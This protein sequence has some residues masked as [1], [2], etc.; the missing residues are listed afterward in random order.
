M[1]ERICKIYDILIQ[2][3]KKNQIRNYIN[4]FYT[5]YLLWFAFLGL[6]GSW[7][8]YLIQ[9]GQNTPY[10][11]C[12][13]TCF[14]A[15]SNTGF[16]TI[17]IQ[18]VEWA[19]Q[20]LILILVCL[21]GTIFNCTFPLFVRLIVNQIKIKKNVTSFEFYNGEI[22]EKLKHLRTEQFALLILI[23]VSFAYITVIPIIGSL[24]LIIYSGSSHA[25]HEVYRESA[26]NFGWGSIFFGVSGFH[27]ASFSVLNLGIYPFA[28]NW[29]YLT[30]IG[31]LVL[32]GEALAPFL[33]SCIVKILHLLTLKQFSPL[34]LL[35]SRGR[36]YHPFIFS[37]WHTF[38]SLLSVLFFTL[39]QFVIV[40]SFDFNYGEGELA[41]FSP[42]YRVWNSFFIAINTRSGGY[43]T[44]NYSLCSS[45]SLF[46]ITIMFYVP[47]YS[48]KCSSKTASHPTHLLSF[49]RWITSESSLVVFLIL[50]TYFA[51]YYP[52]RYDPLY[53]IYSIIF[54]VLS[55]YGT[56]GLSM[57]YGSSILPLCAQF[58]VGGKL[59]V[60]AAMWLGKCRNIPDDSDCFWGNSLEIENKIDE[61]DP[62][63]DLE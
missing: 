25:T 24:L 6:M 61:K 20:F 22:D 18:D 5:L 52:L 15:L 37:N 49:R 12:L 10:I 4:V 41:G 29:F 43:A 33:L 60:I 2:W 42:F 9:P 30:V 17:L 57:G 11:D 38:Y 56:S 62:D 51:E 40:M 44:V 36:N 3:A 39:S 19:N 7:I 50:L 31:I 1:G 59:I 53:S 26:A 58:N 48:Q 28:E 54:E 13:F 35:Y 21:G 16:I 47:S 34:Q 14:S 46:I 27:N 23:L 55:A 32:V 45:A 63:P 8:F